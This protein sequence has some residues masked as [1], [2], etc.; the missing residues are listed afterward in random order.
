MKWLS[1][2]FYEFVP[3]NQCL[4][5]TADNMASKPDD[6]STALLGNPE[7]GR[8]RH[9]SYGSGQTSSQDVNPSGRMMKNM[10][11]NDASVQS[12]NSY[13]ILHQPVLAIKQP[14]YYTKEIEKLKL[15]GYAQPN[16]EHSNS[17]ACW[18]E[19]SATYT[20]WVYWTDCNYFNA[21]CIID[22]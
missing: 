10:A 12:S 19:L 22:M 2:G 8:R 1:A 20:L 5:K 17:Q 13:L 14:W 16:Y 18:P 7:K 9:L 6:P 11:G 4:L 15:L 3:E 21:T